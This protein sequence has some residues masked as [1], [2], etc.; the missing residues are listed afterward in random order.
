MRCRRHFRL[1]NEED[2]I[3]AELFDVLIEIR[4]EFLRFLLVGVVRQST[5]RKLFR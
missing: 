3:E 4:I 2:I 5:V 1:I